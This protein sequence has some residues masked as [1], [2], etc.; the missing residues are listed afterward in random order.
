[1]EALAV[2][3]ELEFGLDLERLGCLQMVME[4]SAP[5]LVGTH[6]AMEVHQIHSVEQAC[7]FGQ[8]LLEAAFEVTSVKV[9]LELEVNCLTCLA[10]VEEVV[11]PGP[12]A[13]WTT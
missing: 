1:V 12:A 2:E 5:L 3:T 6:Q 8:N 9:V 4:E 10:P 11:E 7:P 13:W